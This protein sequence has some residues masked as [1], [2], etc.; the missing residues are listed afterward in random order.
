MS[1]DP[2]F[3]DW[4]LNTLASVDNPTRIARFVRIENRPRGSTNP[5]LW[6]E[7]TD[8]HGQFWLSRPANLEPVPEWA[9][10]S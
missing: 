4:Y 3:G 1:S 6:W 5:G 2:Q 9:G 10:D 7:M 8:G